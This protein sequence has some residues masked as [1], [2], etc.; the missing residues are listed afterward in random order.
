MSR[1]DAGQILARLYHKDEKYLS[2]TNVVRDWVE[3]EGE[4]SDRDFEAAAGN[5]VTNK[6]LVEHDS[7]YALTGDALEFSRNMLVF[8]NVI[9]LTSGIEGPDGEVAVVGFSCLQ[10]GVHDLLM[11][12]FQ[13]G[14]LEL[15]SV[16]AAEVVDYIDAFMRKPLEL[17]APFT[18]KPVP[19]PLEPEAPQIPAKAKVQTC[20]KCGNSVT[21]GKK[22][23]GSCG[24][25]LNTPPH[26]PVALRAS[27][28]TCPKCGSPVTPRKKFCGSCGEKL[29]G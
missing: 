26:A 24:A 13:Q 1:W 9:T 6:Y 19:K 28:S 15:D 27:A 18:P 21:S 22:F 5:L 17:L 7:S 14:K 23:C 11:I 8:S 2:L 25:A 10:G 3:F 4:L 20:P 16:S 29:V 12:D